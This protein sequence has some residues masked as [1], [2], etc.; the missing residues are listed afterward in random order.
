MSF[1]SQVYLYSYNY[2]II[3]NLYYFKYKLLFL[4]KYLYIL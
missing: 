2:Y 3:E 4:T 1:S